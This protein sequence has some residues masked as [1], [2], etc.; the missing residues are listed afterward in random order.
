MTWVILGAAGQIGRSLQ[1]S[2]KHS[3]QPFIALSSKALDITDANLLGQ[4]LDQTR[5]TVIINCTN[6]LPKNSSVRETRKAEH[7][8]ISTP[9]QLAQWC[10]KNNAWLIQLSSDLVFSASNSLDIFTACNET[11]IPSPQ[12]VYGRTK[13]LGELAIFH[14]CM[15]H[16]VIRHGW[17]FSKY[18]RPFIDSVL[19]RGKTKNTPYKNFSKSDNP[20]FMP[21]YGPD[22]AKI[23]IQ[24]ST[25][26]IAGALTGGIYHYAGH[27]SI[28]RQ[29]FFQKIRR[30]ARE[31]GVLITLD[32]YS[33]NEIGTKSNE[34]FNLNTD[35][36]QRLGMRPS[37]WNK[38]LVEVMNE[39]A[40]Q[41]NSSKLS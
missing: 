12:S 6:Y 22:L 10:Q 32:R 25:M 21:T 35:K 3:G 17:V 5:P 16:I 34:S 29:D 11:D 18:N 19:S 7:I 38:G 39:Y 14:H 26:A 1:D 30:L 9:E 20:T 40:C 41:Y 31:H 37:N 27:P 8:N 4:I 33:E 23:I 15:Q 24:F 13:R 2:L 36:S 28:N